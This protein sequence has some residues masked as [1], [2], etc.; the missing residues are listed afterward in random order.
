VAAVAV[1]KPLA[2]RVV[3]VL[4]VQVARQAEL[5]LP[6]TQLVVVAAVKVQAAQALTV[7]QESFTFD[8]RFKTWHTLHK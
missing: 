2:A 1:D 6:Q 4:V 7:V 8:G 3:Q 5:Q